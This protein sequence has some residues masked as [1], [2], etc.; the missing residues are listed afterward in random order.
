MHRT[1]WV[2]ETIFEAM[3]RKEIDGRIG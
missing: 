2:L 3:H 1:D